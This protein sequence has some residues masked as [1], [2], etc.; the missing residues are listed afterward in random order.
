MKRPNTYGVARLMSGLVLG[1]IFGVVSASNAWAGAV[2]TSG[3]VSLGIATTGNLGDEE[4]G[5]GLVL[6]AVGD[7]IAPGCFC[8]GWGVAGDGTVS[9]VNS[10]WASI[11]D[12]G[13]VNITPESF[14]SGASTATSIVHLTSMPDLHVSQAYAPSAGAPTALF[15]DMVTISNT[16]AS[17]ITDI[18]YR[19]SM[20]WD[21]PP[22]VFDE[23]VTI[24]GLPA[25]NVLFS[26]DNGFSTSDPLGVRGPD[27][28]G[29]GSTVNFTDCGPTDHGAL[30]DFGFG[31]LAAGDSKTFSI[32]YGAAYSE[33]DALA[34]LT[35]VGAEVYSLGQ[36][37]T[38][39]GPTLGTP[40]TY[41]FGFKGVGGAPIGTPVIPE[42]TSLSLLG[43]GFVGL[44][45][46]SRRKKTIC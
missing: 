37:H 41:I 14:I 6:A 45:A 36:S 17:T 25:A 22:T 4:S 1:A 34:A 16:S 27:L 46:K 30:F 31:D 13:I 8:E 3:P 18:R 35:S 20:D 29:C 33:A 23:F 7:A 44:V 26:N 5:T 15:E 9:A 42:P 11:A 2:I 24:A 10:G 40:G 39:D 32:F 12:G 19:R 28:G 38:A 21:I 43:M